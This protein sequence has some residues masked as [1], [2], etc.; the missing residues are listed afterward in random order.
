MEV[1]LKCVMPHNRP[2]LAHS[3]KIQNGKNAVTPKVIHRPQHQR[4][5]DQRIVAAGT[6]GSAG[7]RLFHLRVHKWSISDSSFIGYTSVFSSRAVRLSDDVVV[8]DVLYFQP[9]LNFLDGVPAL[10]PLLLFCSIIQG[11]KKTG[12]VA[13]ARGSVHGKEKGVA[14]GYVLIFLLDCGIIQQVIDHWTGNSCC[15]Y[16]G[17]GAGGDC[18]CYDFIK[19]V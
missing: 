18:A 17:L 10:L 15:C 4:M 9:W 12:R 2:C 13:V 19:G 1:C 3:S 6:N 16:I 5:M 8:D 7:K 14:K 11:L